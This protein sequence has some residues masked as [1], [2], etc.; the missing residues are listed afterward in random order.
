MNQPHI[1]VAYIARLASLHLTEEEVDRFSEDLTKVLNYVDQLQSYDVTGVEPMY[2][3]LPVM[4]VM[5]DDVVLSG[6]STEEALVNAPQ[7]ASEQIRVPK[8]VESA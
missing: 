7:Q 1:D 8:V 5:R 6:L 3:P 2:H 4:D